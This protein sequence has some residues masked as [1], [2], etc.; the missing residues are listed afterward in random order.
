MDISYQVLITGI[1]TSCI[2][3]DYGNMDISYQ[4]LITEIGRLVVK[5]HVKTERS[6]C[7]NYGGGKPVQSA[8]DGQRD[9]MQVAVW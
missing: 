3:I 5:R 4:V 1:R 6:M 9:T 2:S 7:A 8:N